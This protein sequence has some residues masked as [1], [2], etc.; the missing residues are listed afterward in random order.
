MAVKWHGLLAVAVHKQEDSSLVYSWMVQ[1]LLVKDTQF[2][3]TL[4]ELQ[5]EGLGLAAAL[6]NQFERNL[7][8]VQCNSVKSHSQPEEEPFADCKHTDTLVRAEMMELFHPVEMMEQMG[9][10]LKS[11]KDSVDH[12][13][14][15]D[16]GLLVHSLVAVG[17]NLG[18]NFDSQGL[19][20]GCNCSSDLVELT[21]TDL[22]VD[23]YIHYPAEVLEA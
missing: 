17:N 7:E 19:V 9:H 4:V 23:S 2:V 14:Q 10:I 5:Q 11:Y 15:P 12:V 3:H 13:A 1:G 21:L 20:S 16:L 8:A 18:C 6:H 22:V